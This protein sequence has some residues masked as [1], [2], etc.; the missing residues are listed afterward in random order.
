[1]GQRI[2]G[3][4]LYLHIRY[5]KKDQASVD[6]DRALQQILNDSQ[7]YFETH[8]LSCDSYR[9]KK[10]A[11]GDLRSA[12]TWFTRGQKAQLDRE[13]ERKLKMMGQHCRGERS[14]MRFIFGM[15]V[16][17]SVPPLLQKDYTCT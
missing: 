5:S 6:E 1:M 14:K 9:N 12:S 3:V 4:P 16:P 11:V 17:A 13:C 15:I 10:R 2:S 7:A 8:L